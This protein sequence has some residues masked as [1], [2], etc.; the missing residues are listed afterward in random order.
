MTPHKLLSI[1]MALDAQFP[2]S[3]SGGKRT[4]KRNNHVGGHPQ[5]YHL[6]WLA[7][8]LVL[9]HPLDTAAFIE[10]ANRLGIKALDEGDH[11]HCQPL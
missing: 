7:W 9:D 10:R 5:S 2:F 11:I 4:T 6:C 3:I 1:L 8:D